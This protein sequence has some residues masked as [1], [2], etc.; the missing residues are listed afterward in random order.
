[1]YDDVDSGGDWGIKTS[2]GDTKAKSNS[3]AKTFFGE[4]VNMARGSTPAANSG[5]GNVTVGLYLPEL[6][7]LFAGELL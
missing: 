6:A 2:M 4:G 3:T 1:M 7:A 5:L